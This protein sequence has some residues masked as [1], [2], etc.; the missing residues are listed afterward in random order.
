MPVCTKHN[1][2][3]ILIDDIWRERKRT[4]CFLTCRIKKSDGG[5]SNASIS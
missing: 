5:V 1:C 4:L 3:C 2:M